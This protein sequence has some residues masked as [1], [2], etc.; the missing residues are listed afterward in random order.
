MAG[1]AAFSR[2]GFPFAGSRSASYDL[3]VPRNACYLFR[4]HLPRV[5]E[6]SDRDVPMMT[7]EERQEAEEYMKGQ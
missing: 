2:I 6:P 1:S 7:M 3:A 4:H 5:L